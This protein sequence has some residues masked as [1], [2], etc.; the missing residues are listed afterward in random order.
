MVDTVSV[1][2]MSGILKSAILSTIDK[3]TILSEQ[4]KNHINIR[5]V[6]SHG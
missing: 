5:P 2:S 3:K 1:P 6:F 4:I